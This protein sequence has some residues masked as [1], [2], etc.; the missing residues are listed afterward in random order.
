MEEKL[1]QEIL[2]LIKLWE[3]KDSITLSTPAKGGEIKIYG[4]YNNVIEFK[5]KIINAIEIRK[6]ANGLIEKEV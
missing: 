3:D 6:Y 2:D 4:N 5:A 1:K